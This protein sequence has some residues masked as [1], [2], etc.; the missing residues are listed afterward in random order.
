LQGKIP[1]V[2]MVWLVS[3]IRLKAPPVISSS[4]ISPL[5]SSGQRSRASWAS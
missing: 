1:M 3:R 5:T 4:C 2:T